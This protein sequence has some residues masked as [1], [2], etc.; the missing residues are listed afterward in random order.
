MASETHAMAVAPRIV[1]RDGVRFGIPESRRDT[2]GRRRITK[3]NHNSVRASN[4]AVVSR[5]QSM[6]Q[7][8]GPDSDSAADLSRL[9][10]TGTTISDATARAAICSSS[11]AAL[12]VD[13]GADSSVSSDK[14]ARFKL[15]RNRGE[16]VHWLG[17][18]DVRS[19][20][21]R[22]RRARRIRC[23][24]CDLRHWHRHRSIT[25]N[26]EYCLLA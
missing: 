15:N 25:E 7:P 16:C 20:L 14:S 4:G 3:Q 10:S 26:V 18:A 6:S 19:V 8:I 12:Q 23:L 21:P 5:F 1:M 9:N 17:R 24:I 13:S 2:R 22:L 11:E